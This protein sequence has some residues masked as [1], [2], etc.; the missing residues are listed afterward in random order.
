[1]IVLL[2]QNTIFVIVICITVIFIAMKS[3]GIAIHIGA[4]HRNLCRFK[5]NVINQKV[6]RTATFVVLKSM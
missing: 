6:H 3:F 5:I 2:N 1:M 4:S